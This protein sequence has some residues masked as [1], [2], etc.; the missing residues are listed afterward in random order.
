[1]LLFLMRMRR[2]IPFEG[3]RLM[4]GVSY[5]TA[6]NYYG[7]MLK[8]FHNHVVPRLLHPLSGPAVDAMTPQRVKDDLPGARVIWDG[9]GFALKSKENTTVGRLL[10]SGYHHRSEA[11][12]VFGNGALMGVCVSPI[13]DA[14]GARPRLYDERNMGFS[15]ALIWRQFGRGYNRLQ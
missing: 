13:I 1:M 7:E 15:L 9:T 10:Y 5:G 11:M 2:R 3:L 12:A 4:F 6:S 14:L 8:R